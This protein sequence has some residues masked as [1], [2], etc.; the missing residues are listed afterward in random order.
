[1]KPMLK[2]LGLMCIAPMVCAEEVVPHM[3][4]DKVL[5]QITQRQWVATQTALLSVSINVTLNSPDLVKARAEIMTRLNQVAKG[6]W[7]LTEFERS[8]DSS[9]LEKLYVQAQARVNQ[10]YLT[11]AYQNAKTASAP[12]A[13]YEV[14]GIE[15]KPSL[16][17]TSG[18]RTQIRE[19]LY[20][21]VN[22]EIGRINKAYPNQNYSVNQLVFTEGEGIKPQA[23]ASSKDVNVLVATS[24]PP[25]SVSNELVMT[26]MVEA[27]SN[28]K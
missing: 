17:E 22:D 20:K 7:H 5:F 26:A 6:E 3:V 24:S 16:E 23:Y 27:A 28:R 12:G 14:S 19:Q 21:S 15:F 11:N 2:L 10:S 1:M 25:I 4:L 18:V 8:Q 9:G 13:K